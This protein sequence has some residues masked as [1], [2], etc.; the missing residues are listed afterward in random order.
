MTSPHFDFGALSPLMHAVRRAHQS[1]Q[2]LQKGKN[3]AFA[4]SADAPACDDEEKPTGR[5]VGDRDRGDFCD[6]G[7]EFL[8]A[9][10]EGPT[11]THLILLKRIGQG[12]IGLGPR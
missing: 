5:H 9:T 6:F 11:A 7:V 4:V 1:H 3:M 12:Y 8:F 2:H 10:K